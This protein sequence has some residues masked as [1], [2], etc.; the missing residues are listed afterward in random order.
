MAKAHSKSGVTV[1]KAA[2]TERYYTVG[3]ASHNGKPNPPS[4][5][6]L[7]GRWLEESGFI[8]GMPVTVTVERGRIII[9]TQINL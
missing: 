1:N 5:I 3:Y 9:E 4:A 8:T 7:K 2:K 6:N